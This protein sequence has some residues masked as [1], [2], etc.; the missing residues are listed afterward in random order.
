MLAGR[1]QRRT[2]TLATP[3]EDAFRVRLHLPSAPGSGA[4]LCQGLRASSRRS[5]RPTGH[6]TRQERTHRWIKLGGNVT[7]TPAC[8]MARLVY[9]LSHD[10]RASSQ[11][12][13]FVLCPSTVCT[14]ADIF[15]D[16]VGLV[17]LPWA[18]P[19][20]HTRGIQLLC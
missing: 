18:I 19:F 12:L 1:L 2:T 9:A 20:R 16:R 14:A 11:S 13:Q 3:M 5:N 8:S 15:C 17:A 4:A 7:T 10:H 6:S